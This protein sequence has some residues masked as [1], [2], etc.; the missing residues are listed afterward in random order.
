MSGSDVFSG[1]AETVAAVRS[2]A[3]TSLVP[4]ASNHPAGRV[5]RALVGALG[6]SGL[7]RRLFPSRYGGDAGEVATATALCAIR[8]GLACESGEAETAFALQ[9]LGSYP[10]LLAGSEELRNKWLPGVASGAVVAAFALSEPD[11][12]SDASAVALSAEPAEGGYRLTGTKLWISNAPD[13]DIYTVFARTSPG[14]GAR[15]I[16]AFLVEG[17]SPGL[18]GQ[19]MDLIGEHAIGRLDFDGVL[20]P[21]AAALGEADRGFRVAM[22]TLNRFRPSV[23]A[24]AVGMA[25]R[26]LEQAVA[27]A[28]S[29]SA[30]GQPIG[31]FQGVSH[32]LADLATQV[33][34]A[35][36]LVLEAALGHDAGWDSAA[37]LSAMAKLF[38]TEMAQRVV[39]GAVQVLGAR[40]L[41]RGHPLSSLYNEVRALRIYEG[42]SEIQKIIIARHLLG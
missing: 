39:D 9:G 11:A 5:D 7:L 17:G 12:G 13:A 3:R 10:V 28:K 30:F 14:A 41:V 24:G 36:L 4:S 23:G 29:R 16:T 20:V 25:Q 22:R 18:S 19:P 31:G 2:L 37:K 26:A 15:G 27:H 38:A 35:R 42:T 40:G 33:E 6:R 34:A 21:A 32:P 1:H 8:E